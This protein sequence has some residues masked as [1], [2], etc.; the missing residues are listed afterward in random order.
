MKDWRDQDAALDAAYEE[1]QREPFGPSIG[2]TIGSMIGGVIYLSFH[3]AWIV[4]VAVVLYLIGRAVV[5]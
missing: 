3:V 5:G 4:L 2:E 1:M